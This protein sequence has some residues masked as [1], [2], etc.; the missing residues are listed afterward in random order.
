MIPLSFLFIV[1]TFLVV[2]ELLKSFS[3]NGDFISIIIDFIML[4]IC[5]SFYLIIIYLNAFVLIAPGN[6]KLKFYRQTGIVEMPKRWLRG[7]IKGEIITF[8]FCDNAITQSGGMGARSLHL[9]APNGRS[10]LLMRADMRKELSFLLWYMDRN[11]PLPPGKR[12][13][14]NRTQDY[15]RSKAACFPAP[16][17]ASKI[18]IT[19]E[20][21]PNRGT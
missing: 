18:R 15:Q 4:S 13:Y 8:S 5:L 19:P 9:K 11:R 21:I 12:L 7:W 2:P 3:I 10:M 14:P 1:E 16:L 17:R 6:Y 20:V